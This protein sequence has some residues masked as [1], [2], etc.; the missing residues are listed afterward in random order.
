M[1]LRFNRRSLWVLGL[2]AVPAAAAQSGGAPEPRKTAQPVP[3]KLDGPIRV[4]VKSHP[5][6]WNGHAYHLLR[7]WEA[8]FQRSS[9]GRLTA[10]LQLSTITFDQV[11]Y[12]V[13]AAVLDAAGT[14]L[15][16]ARAP[17][18]VERV[19]LGKALTT[20]G[21]LELDFGISLDYERAAAF[22]LGISRRRVLTP[23]EWQNEAPQA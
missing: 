19:W 1:P 9:E 15:G 2:G 23:D 14:L 20:S 17:V 12:D 4:D 8:R 13:S 3:L 16:T 18:Q 5:V 6:L 10:V 11:E 7:I 22:S 21:K